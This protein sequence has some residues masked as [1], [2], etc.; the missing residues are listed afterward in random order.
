MNADHAAT[1]SRS[2]CAR[3]AE[4]V[5]AGIAGLVTGAALSRR[6]WSVRI[7]ERG[8]E[9]RE[10]GAGISLREN[11]LQALEALGILDQAVAG[12]RITQWQLRDERLRV[13]TAGALDDRSR[14]FCVTRPTL[15]RA[16]ADAAVAAGANVVL[17]STVVDASPRASSA[18]ATG[19]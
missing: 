11:G 14:F 12:E 19:P 6:G 3:R 15:H 16:L 10:L 18:S 13:L 7:H 8:T 1:T 5:G 4:V 2:P 17:G 9:L